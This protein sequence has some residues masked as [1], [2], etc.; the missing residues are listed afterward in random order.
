[1]PTGDAPP[2]YLFLAH[3]SWTA[4]FWSSYILFFFVTSWAFLR[5]RRAVRGDDRDRGSKSIIMIFSFMAV[6]L[7]FSGPYIFPESQIGLPPAPVFWLAMVLFWAGTILYP[8][9][10]LTLGAFFRTSVQLLDGQRLITSGPYRYLRHPAYTAGVLAFSGIGL[11][12]GN[13]FSFGETILI[14]LLAYAFRIRVEEQA[15]AERFGPEFDAHRR[16]TWAII[17]LV[18]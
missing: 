17:P 11:A 4:I 12:M 18:W 8:W 15:L 10:I 14:V 7:A 2:P 16:R 13:W 9:A 3:A 6:A 5:E 1:M